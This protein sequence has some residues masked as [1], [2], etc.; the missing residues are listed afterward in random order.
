[1][2]IIVRR[3]ELNILATASNFIVTELKMTGVEPVTENMY[4]NLGS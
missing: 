2:C 4:E 3:V 1:M